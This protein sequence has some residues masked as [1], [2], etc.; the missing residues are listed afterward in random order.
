MEIDTPWMVALGAAVV[1]LTL[2]DL[3]W[4]VVAAAGGRGPL[5][6]VVARSLWRLA[7]IGRPSH[8]RLQLAGYQVAVG[9]PILWVALAWAGFAT[10]FLADDDAVVNAATQQPGPALARVAYAAGAM[11]GAG[12]GFTAG[13]A[14]WQLVNNVAA[15]VG[16]AIFT[17]AVTYLIQLVTAVSR[18]RAMCARIAG[19]GGSPVE[20][21]AIAAR[22]PGLGHLPD[23]VAS[24]TATLSQ[25]GRDHL[26][27]PM[28]QFFHVGDRDADTGRNIAFFDEVL[29]ILDHGLATDHST[30]VRPARQAVDQ[31][32]GTLELPT[33]SDEPP[34]PPDLSPLRRLTDDAV[35]DAAFHAAVGRL[36]ERRTALRSF[37]EREGWTWS[38]V[39]PRSEAN[40]ERRV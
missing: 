38:D 17:L 23:H 11:A 34:P 2:V 5:S 7:T 9:L 29:T 12:A 14:T 35:D 28:I 4:T 16:L 18:E 15:L 8:R 27:L 20:A 21:V 33:I 32:F 13:T 26:T 25:I 30:L 24:I 10:M 31:F 37:L 6:N 40:V 39:D 19:L 36:Q 3:S 1:V 22:S